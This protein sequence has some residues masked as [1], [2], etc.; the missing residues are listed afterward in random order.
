VAEKKGGTDSDVFLA[1]V[2]DAE[3][4]RVLHEVS[5]SDLGLKPVIMKGDLEDAQRYLKVNRSPKVLLVDV[6]KSQLPISD[7]ARLADVCEPGVEVIAIGHVNDVG[8]FRG[9]VNLG[10]RDYVVKP[11]TENLVVRNISAVQKGAVPQ[12]AT[13]FL[14]AGNVVTVLGARGGVGT[15]TIA[16]NLGWMLSDTLHKRI[17]LMDLNLHA[18]VLC[19]FFDV[20]P[21]PGLVDLLGPEEHIDMSMVEKAFVSHTDRLSIATAQLALQ[22]HFVPQVSSLKKTLSLLGQSSHYTIIDCPKNLDFNL[23]KTIVA[24]S[25]VLI[26][27]CDLTFL[28]VRDTARYLDLAKTVGPAQQ[29]IF[30]VANRVGEYKKGEF[31]QAT[32]EQVVHRSVDHCLP[33][34]NAGV[35]E[36]LNKGQP[37]SAQAGPFAKA[38]PGLVQLLIGREL[39]AKKKGLFW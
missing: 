5:Y 6:S 37:V 13:S 4:E 23:M 17:Y 14:G 2:T 27:V 28:S 25:Q 38:L 39:K 8:V 10:V 18:G 35:L 36:A 11:L 20:S 15:S 12:Q 31:P 7:M 21:L 3:S 29:R 16:A 9:L 30:V 22:D 19:Y 1:F 34:D 26:I 32:F 33:F 24:E